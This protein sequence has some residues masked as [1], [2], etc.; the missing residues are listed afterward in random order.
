M[1]QT[2]AAQVIGVSAMTINRRLN[3]GLHLLAATLRDLSPG[4]E[5]PGGSEPD[6]V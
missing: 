4:E 3:R 1:S 2:E 6:P 5:G